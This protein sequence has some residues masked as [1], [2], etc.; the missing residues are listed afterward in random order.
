MAR[1]LVPSYP[2]PRHRMSAPYGT[3]HGL[4]FCADV[5]ALCMPPPAC[6]TAQRLLALALWLDMG[7][8]DVTP[9]LYPP[10]GNACDDSGVCSWNVTG[11]PI[12]NRL[13]KRMYPGRAG[14]GALLFLPRTQ[15]CNRVKDNSSC[16]GA[17]L[18]F[19]SEYIPGVSCHFQRFCP[20]R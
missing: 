20:V 14:S 16:G 18:I 10:S 8:L 11:A 13:V 12:H 5:F 1:C 9:R 7:K 6:D 17:I 2:S 15:S 3:P 4:L 19:V